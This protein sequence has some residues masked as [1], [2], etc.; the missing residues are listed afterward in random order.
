MRSS[1]V[2][3][4]GR[5]ER[6]ETLGVL[7]AVQLYARSQQAFV[8]IERPPPGSRRN[9]VSASTPAS[10]ERDTTRPPTP[11]LESS[12]ASSPTPSVTKPV[13]T[14][15]FIRI[16][17]ARDSG[18]AGYVMEVVNNFLVTSASPSVDEFEM[19]ID[20]LSRTRQ[21]DQPPTVL[22][23]TYK[24][25][26]Q[27]GLLPSYSVYTSVLRTLL[28]REFETVAVIQRIEARARATGIF[29]KAPPSMDLELI[30]RYKAGM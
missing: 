12:R 25:M 18:D 23:D 11:V 20:A 29:G 22:L 19:A 10:P 16:Q 15:D 6:A 3:L 28:A 27:R 4:T 30:E 8:A 7:R 24:A 5:S 13:P 26:I 14:T 9:S 17:E 21:E 2:S 1:S